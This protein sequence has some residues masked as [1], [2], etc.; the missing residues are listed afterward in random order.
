MPRH[1]WIRRRF[2]RGLPAQHFADGFNRIDLEE[3]V[4]FTVPANV[5]SMRV[6]QRLGLTHE[7]GQVT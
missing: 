3:I 7:R 2:A 1:D 5:R 4:S 6:I